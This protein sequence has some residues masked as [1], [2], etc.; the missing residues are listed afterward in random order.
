MSR[1][2]FRRAPEPMGEAV[3]VHVIETAAPVAAKLNLTP[4]PPAA[5]PAPSN[6]QLDVKLR[7][8]SKL[9]D[10]LD[11]AKLEK[12]ERGDMRS[13]VRQLVAD[14]VKAERLAFNTAELEVLGDSIFDEM[15]GLGPIEPLLKD[16]S[17]SDILINGPSRSTSS[18]AASWRSRPIRFRDND[19]LLRI[20]NRIAAGWPPDRRSSPMM[21][22]PGRPWAGAR[23]HPHTCG[24]ATFDQGAGGS[25]IPQGWGVCVYGGVSTRAVGSSTTTEYDPISERESYGGRCVGGGGVSL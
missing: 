6:D 18:G 14:F 3:E 15:V 19:H 4:E 21:D 16:D 25:S 23:Q 10:E 9:I 13:H 22:A 20:V 24:H 7:L 8:H 17:I 12:L 1:F 5:P 2:S 11:L